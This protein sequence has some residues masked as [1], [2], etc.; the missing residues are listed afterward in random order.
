MRCLMHLLSSTIQYVQHLNVLNVGIF[1]PGD[2]S[3]PMKE[4]KKR[5]NRPERAKLECIINEATLCCSSLP[6]Y[7]IHL[8]LTSGTRKRILGSSE[9]DP[10][11]S[12]STT[13][14]GC[15]FFAP[16]KIPFPF[17]SFSLSNRQVAIF[18]T[19]HVKWMTRHIDHAAAIVPIGA[20]CR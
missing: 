3:C 6:V 15:L 5:K 2:A 4:I 8:F 11:F 18:L 9:P 19:G 12:I 20:L 17:F 16:S 13:C 10:L 1:Q 7:T 14:R